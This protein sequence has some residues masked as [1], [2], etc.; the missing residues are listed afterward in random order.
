MRCMP[1]ATRALP[2]GEAQRTSKCN[3]TQMQLSHE[4]HTQN[5][6]QLLPA[7]Q[8]QHRQLVDAAVNTTCCAALQHKASRNSIAQTFMRAQTNTKSPCNTVQYLPTATALH[9]AHAGKSSS[10][11]MH[12]NSM[13]KRSCTQT[14]DWI[15]L[16]PVQRCLIR[17]K[18]IRASHEQLLLAI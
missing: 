1:M 13:P 15:N 5:F 4:Q 14:C 11:I 2:T 16:C 18:K 8:P 6:V 9:G 12:A 7:K 17:R 3:I 10:N